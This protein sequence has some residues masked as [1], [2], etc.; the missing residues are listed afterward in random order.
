MQ[1]P[2]PRPIS[3]GKGNSTCDTAG[4]HKAEVG[5]QISYQISFFPLLMAWRKQCGLEEAGLCSTPHWGKLRPSGCPWLNADAVPILFPALIH[6]H[7]WIRRGVA[8]CRTV[9]CLHSAMQSQLHG[10]LLQGIQLVHLLAGTG[11]KGLLGL[12]SLVPTHKIGFQKATEIST[13]VMPLTAGHNIFPIFHAKH[14][15]P[16]RNQETATTCP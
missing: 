12:W 4:S 6:S 10:S 11:L 16:I 7:I 8:P 9:Q 1:R 13:A 15:A 3:S 2:S 5:Y 14:R